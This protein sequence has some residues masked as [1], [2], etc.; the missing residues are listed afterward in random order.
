MGTAFSIII[1][2]YN[3]APYL[4][5]CL[6]SCLDQ[7]IPPED[8]ELIVVNDGSTDN[9]LEIAQMFASDHPSVKIISQENKGLSE[10]RNAGLAAAQ[11]DF[12]WFVDSDDT[13][14]A[15]CLN[16]LRQQ[17]VE[18]ELDVLACDAAIVNAQGLA[19][20]RFYPP[21]LSGVVLSGPDMMRKGLLQSAC[22]PYF[23]Y[24]RA[25]L[26]EG[27]FRFMPGI[28]HEDEEWVPR[29]LYQART[30]G[31]TDTVCYYVHNRPD[32][33]MATPKVKRS[34][35]LITVGLSL[36]R[37]ANGI[38]ASDRY[39]IS[40]RIAESLSYALKQSI[41]YSPADTD[42]FQAALLANRRMLKHFRKSRVF[43]YRLMGL[44]LSAFPRRSVSLYKAMQRVASRIG[45]TK[46]R[47]WRDYPS[48]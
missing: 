23:L 37:F 46:K 30:I 24:R 8:Y 21:S 26:Q 33:I 27:G 42:N 22:A 34:L 20:H 41:V 4:E 12:V 29:V 14:T 44:I 43:S 35:D 2:A 45:L 9:T 39:L 16:H 18:K 36:D 38:V 13:I 6:K 17:F 28:Y 40:R 47:K 32:S 15:N 48:E 7:D 25:Y 19:V 10:A 31:F 1:P 11:G 3:V 5:R